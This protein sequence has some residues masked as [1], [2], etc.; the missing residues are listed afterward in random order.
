MATMLIVFYL[1]VK[2]EFEQK[3]HCFLS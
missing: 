1:L 3:S 2:P